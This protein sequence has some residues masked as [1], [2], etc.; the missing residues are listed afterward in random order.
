MELKDRFPKDYIR[1]LS[2]IKG[3]IL[4]W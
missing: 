3:S 1:S 4:Y 2:D